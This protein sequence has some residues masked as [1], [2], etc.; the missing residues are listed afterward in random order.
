MIPVNWEG[1][2]HDPTQEKGNAHKTE[3][4]PCLGVDDIFL[5]FFARNPGRN[6]LERLKSNSEEGNNVW[7]SQVSP[8]DSVVVDSLFITFHQ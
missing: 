4:V 7:V 5:Q 6:E 3:S 8:R 1:R 2:E